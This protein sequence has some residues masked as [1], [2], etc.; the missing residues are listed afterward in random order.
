MPFDWKDL[1]IPIMTVTEV[2]GD[3]IMYELSLGLVL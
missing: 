1:I 3:I 2:L